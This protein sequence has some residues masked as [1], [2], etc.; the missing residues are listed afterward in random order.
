MNESWALELPLISAHV[1][2]T[3][4]EV[5]ASCRQMD[6]AFA[7]AL[8]PLTQH[9]QPFATINRLRFHLALIHPDYGQSGG[10]RRSHHRATGVY[11]SEA[12]IDYAAWEAPIWS[13]RVQEYAAALQRALDRVPAS[14]ISPSERLTVQRLIAAARDN[15]ARHPPTRI[16]WVAL[17]APETAASRAASR[18]LR[19]D[20]TPRPKLM[21]LYRR[22]E[23]VLHYREAWRR[24][25]NLFEHWGICGESGDTRETAYADSG[26]LEHA[27]RKFE[28]EARSDGFR[29]IPNSKH[30]QLIAQFQLTDAPTNTDPDAFRHALEDH[31][32]QVLGGLGLGHCD[33]GAIGSGTLEAFCLVVDIKTALRVLPQH[34]EGTPFSKAAFSR[35]G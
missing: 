14:R 29:P 28:G 35:Y 4:R 9:A 34:V 1:F 31:M 2:A 17:D 12:R 21:K 32:D 6:Q 11:F 22:I 25:L 26:T 7:Q 33:G 23:G 18:A 20:T 24:E 16:E 3:T 13:D 15:V 30:T 10:A 27:F 19:L 8:Q 5:T